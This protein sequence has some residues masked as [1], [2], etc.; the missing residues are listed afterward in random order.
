MHTTSHIDSAGFSLT[1]T[2]VSVHAP[3]DIL[4]APNTVAANDAA[5]LPFA[6]HAI[7][8]RDVYFDYELI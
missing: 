1:D 6:A 3:V 8:M 2:V 4:N 5:P 7:R